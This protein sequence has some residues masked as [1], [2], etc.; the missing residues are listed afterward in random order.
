MTFKA[1]LIGF[2]AIARHGHLPWYLNRPSVELSAVVEPTPSGRAAARDLLPHVEV[3]ASLKELL[4]SQTLNLVDI[5][6][7]PAAHRELILQA[8]AGGIHVICEKPFVRS[9]QELQHIEMLRQPGGPVIAACHN[10]YFAPVIRRGLE[11]VAAGLI[12]EPNLIRF[13]AHRPQAARGAEHWKPQWRQLASRGGGI[14]ADLGYHGIYL[15]SRI[16][17]RPA[18]C[19]H[20]NS[21]QMSAT[22]DGVENRAFVALDYGTGKRAELTLSWLSNVRETCLQVQGSQ[23]ALIIQGDRL[24]LAVIGQK[25]IEERFES[26]TTDSWHQA[27]IAHTLDRFLADVQ[28]GDQAAGWQDIAWSVSALDAAYASIK[29]RAPVTTRYQSPASPFEAS[30]LGLPAGLEAG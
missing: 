6:A 7:P 4:Q 17:E 15:A 3:F 30:L 13:A 23:G 9:L 29:S 22:L 25:E 12:G 1:A 11:F 19:V 2:G 16:F 14:I 27:W 10:W 21:V 28:K 5:A 18:V 26:L 24:R 20:A 8:V